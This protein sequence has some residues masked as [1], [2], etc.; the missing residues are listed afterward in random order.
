MESISLPEAGTKVS[1]KALTSRKGDWLILRG[2]IGT[3]DD[4]EKIETACI[5]PASHN[6]NSPKLEKAIKNY[7]Q[8]SK[9]NL[10]ATNAKLKKKYGSFVTLGKFRS[11]TVTLPEDAFEDEGFYDDDYSTWSVG[12]SEALEDKVGQM[13]VKQAIALA[14]STS[15]NDDDDDDD[16][17]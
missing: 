15:S 13:L 4:G 16:E 5:F 17:D 14:E 11:F 2:S 9:R 7:C 3:S 1:F 12:P 10:L 6:D 8:R